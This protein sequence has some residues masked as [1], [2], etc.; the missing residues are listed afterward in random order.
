VL[1]FP[2][3]LRSLGARAHL[4][5]APAHYTRELLSG[6]GLGSDSAPWLV[7]GLGAATH[8]DCVVIDWP[9]GRQTQIEN[10]AINRPIAVR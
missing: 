3:A 7:F 1:A 5:G 8:A 4:E 6:A 9:D 2:D 10:P